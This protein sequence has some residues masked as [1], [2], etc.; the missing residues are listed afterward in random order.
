MSRSTLLGPAEIRDLADLLGIQPTKKLGQNFVH[1]ANTVR[2]IVAAS[3]VSA[4]TSVVEIGP[5][6]GSL[7]LGLL[8]AGADVVAVEI[9]KRLAA[10]LPTTVSLLQPAADLSVV[11]DDAMRVV[12]LPSA[13][14]HL[15]ANL[16]YNISVPVL[17]HFLE[18]FPTLTRGLVMVQAEVGLRLAAEPGSKIYGSPSI[19]AA[20]Y[21]EFSTAGQVSR[22]VFWPVPN[23]DSILVAFDRKEARGTEE[24][25]L[26][27]FELVDAAFQQRRKMLRQSL[28]SVYGS[29]AAASDALE[30]AGLSPTERGEQL[31][32]DDFLALAR[33]TR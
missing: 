15:V 32:V 6:L 21:G 26:A 1:D 2:R 16:P 23:V 28:S 30:A 4:G 10:Q 20:W 25:R 33:A 12:E 24:E 9:D 7:T 17:L 13:P 3:G 14:T 22:Q 8:E 27:V 19:K 5:G 31:T 11:V 18:H 29:S